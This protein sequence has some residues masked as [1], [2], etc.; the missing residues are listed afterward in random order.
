[1]WSRKRVSLVTVLTALLALAGGLVVWN[2]PRIR[3]SLGWDHRPMARILVTSHSEFVA[4]KPEEGS[5]PIE[6]AN[7]KRFLKTQLA[8]LKSRQVINSSLQHSEI[9]ELAAISGQDDPVS[10]ML[11]HLEVTNPED[12]EVLELAL[13]PG[14]GA[15][16]KDQAMLVNA[17]KQAYLDVVVNREYELGADRQR[18]LRQRLGTYQ[19][20]IK[21]RR[22]TLRSPAQ[23]KGDKST[24]ILQA[25]LDIEKR[26]ALRPMQIKLWLE[27]AG[28]EAL[29]ARRKKSEDS[30]TDQGRKEIAKI[31]DQLAALDA[32]HKAVESELSRLAEKTAAVTDDSMDLQDLQDELKHYEKAARTINA[33]LEMLTREI[34]APSRIRSYEDATAS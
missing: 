15:T 8:L 23:K 16:A 19:D 2:M 11:D 22:E 10:W 27:K 18:R 31:E 14:S 33:E 3:A 21:S 5:S 24:L 7:Y 6:E 25:Q 17:I 1:M 4:F 34:Q 26:Q 12:T 30:A 13:A 28:V 32:Q 29:L 20:L 9:R